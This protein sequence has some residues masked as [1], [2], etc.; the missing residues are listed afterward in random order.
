MT[1]IAGLTGQ[2]IIDRFNDITDDAVNGDHALFLMNAAKDEVEAGRDWYFNRGFDNSQVWSP[3]NT[4]L[5]MKNLP[6]D[7]LVERQI[8]LNGDILPYV[9]VPFEMRERFKDTYRRFYIDYKNN[10]FAICGSGPGQ[11]TINF[12]YAAASPAITLSTM[13]IWPTVFHAYLP[14]KMAEIFESTSEADDVGF[15]MSR[16]QLRQANMTL[17]GMIQWDARLKTRDYNDRNSQSY[18]L[19]GQPNV[20][21]TEFLM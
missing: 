2:N 16:E 15:R 21:G 6:A 14:F 13:P 19:Q 12:Y 17:K 4:Y 5:S 11:T 3:G 7:F 18:D 10:Q 9:K 20:V 8:Y 1:I